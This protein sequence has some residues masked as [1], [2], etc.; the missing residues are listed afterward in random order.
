ML[1]ADSGVSS[2]SMQRPGKFVN[3]LREKISEGAF[4]GNQMIRH[5][6][7]RVSSAYEKTAKKKHFL[8][9]PIR[10][11]T[12]F[13]GCTSK[14]PGNMMLPLA[15]YHR[16][17]NLS[18]ENFLRMERTG[19]RYPSEACRSNRKRASTPSVSHRF[20]IWYGQ[21]GITLHTKE[22]IE[23]L[24]PFGAQTSPAVASWRFLRVESLLIT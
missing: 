18:T 8:P 19:R 15:K 1:P 11:Q 5:R 22:R 21:P 6:R 7:E 14:T 4:A 10:Q 13:P 12:L 16:Q 9:L 2:D 20:F 24:L 23:S 3:L 17:T